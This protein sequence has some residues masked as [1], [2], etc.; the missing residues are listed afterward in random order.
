[1][2]SSS[3][4][5]E[6]GERS[7]EKDI[8]SFSSLRTEKMSGIQVKAF[9]NVQCRKK[10][11]ILALLLPRVI[12]CKFP[13]SA[14]PEILHRP[15]SRTWLFI[16]YSGERWSYLPILAISLIQFSLKGW[17]N[18]LFELPPCRCQFQQQWG[19]SKCETSGGRNAQDHSQASRSMQP[20]RR[21]RRNDGVPRPKRQPNH[22]R[23]TQRRPGLSLPQKTGLRIH[24]ADVFEF[25]L[26]PTA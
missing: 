5:V 7:R 22:H 15:V 17:E 2:L 18:V 13:P 9:S 6:T 10:G 3:L 8:A 14:S 24:E 1:M 21:R 23:L 4:K 19:I 20:S 25:E 26:A 16:A 12:N 11:H